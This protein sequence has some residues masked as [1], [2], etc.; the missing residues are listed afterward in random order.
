MGG[1]FA[2]LVPGFFLTLFSFL[3]LVPL[4]A[5]GLGTL[6]IWVGAPILAFMLLAA[7]G[8]ARENRELLRRWGEDVAEPDYRR[9]PDG[10][11]RRLLTMIGDLQAWKEALHGSLVAFPLRITT[12]VASITWVAAG[13]GGITYFLWAVFLPEGG[14]GLGQLLLRLADRE[15]GVSWYVVESVTCFALGAVLLV[16]APLVVRT[17]CRVDAAVARV[18]LTDRPFGA[19]PQDGTR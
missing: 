9:A 4:F 19:G 6:V 3:V 13:L 7:S 10:G 8:F 14:Q 16:L 1:D 5:L 2:Y 18:F 12:F 11:R 17:C 15:V